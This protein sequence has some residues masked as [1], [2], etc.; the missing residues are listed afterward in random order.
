MK[1]KKQA[2]HSE[3]CKSTSTNRWWWSCEDYTWG[4]WYSTPAKVLDSTLSFL[5]PHPKHSAYFPE[6]YFSWTFYVNIM[7]EVFIH[8][9]LYF[10]SLCPPH[11]TLPPS[12]DT[13]PP[14]KV[15]LTCYM[16]ATALFLSPLWSCPLLWPH[17]FSSFVQV[18]T[19]LNVGN[20]WEKTCSIFF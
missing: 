20:A 14:S 2:P 17:P 11:W 3:N 16:C 10:L 1:C 19:V 9:C 15:F 12:D 7:N 13:L 8:V 5:C 18:H 6:V 4:R